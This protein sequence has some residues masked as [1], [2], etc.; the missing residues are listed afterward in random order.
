MLMAN[1][2]LWNSCT[3][4]HSNTTPVPGFSISNVSSTH[5]Q[6]NKLI[7]INGQGFDSVKANNHIY[8][9]GKEAGVIF[10]SNM[11]LG[12]LVP[13]GAGTGPI[14][15][16]VDGQTIVGPVFTYDY[17]G[18]VSTL[19]GDK[20]VNGQPTLGA[21]D[22]PWGITV[23]AGG[24]L[25]V[26]NKQSDLIDK[27]TP[28][29]SASVVAGTGSPGA[30][31]GTGTAASFNNPTG[32][33]IDPAGNIFVADYFNGL[34]RKIDPSLA[35]TTFAGAPADSIGPSDI[36]IDPAGNIYVASNAQVKK[37]TPSGQIS[38]FATQAL[39]DSGTP[40]PSTNL[41]LV[42]GVAADQQGNI[43]VVYNN[44]IRKIT[45]AGQI[46]TLYTF[47]AP[48]YLPSLPTVYVN[49]GR[50]VIDRLGN[51]FFTDPFN[52]NVCELTT[53]GYVVPIAGQSGTGDTNGLGAE[54]GF[55]DM[56]G[57]TIDRNGNLYVLEYNANDI[58][59]IVLE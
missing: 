19:I 50:L 30:M 45:Q 53:Q 40:G 21:L 7:Y 10:F 42:T 31:N 57:I 54:A 27:I 37:I 24:N 16:T 33:A 23:D 26:C 38:T 11:Q 48:S 46:S 29:G 35:V 52:Y 28:A 22:D 13:L 20:N 43:I 14:T 5:G 39:L 18:L 8:F 17:I 25:Y 9:N 58:R 1:V 49:Y 41:N 3:K 47:T 2:V 15:V 4:P 12:A 34:V 56:M 36:T 44:F 6:Y 59:K 32:L 51:I 55:F